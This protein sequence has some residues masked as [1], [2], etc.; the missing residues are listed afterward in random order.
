VG[1]SNLSNDDICNEKYDHEIFIYLS[2]E[3]FVKKCPEKKKRA[4]V[5]EKQIRTIKIRR[6]GVEKFKPRLFYLLY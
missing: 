4:D 5:D 2:S 6:K 1:P 3:R